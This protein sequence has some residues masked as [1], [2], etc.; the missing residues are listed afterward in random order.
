MWLLKTA[1]S[2]LAWLRGAL[3]WLWTGFVD[4]YRTAIPLLVI[5]VGSCLFA[6]GWSKSG[7]ETTVCNVLAFLC[8]A[9][10]LDLQADR[11]KARE[12]RK[13]ADQMIKLITNGESLEI[14]VNHYIIDGEHQ[15]SSLTV[16]EKK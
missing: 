14:S 10:A 7:T 1:V 13:W 6:I 11:V 4:L 9:W 15:L 5:L 16:R 8:W 12:A 3:R 2:A